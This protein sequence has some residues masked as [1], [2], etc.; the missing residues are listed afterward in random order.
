MIVKKAE[1]NGILELVDK[2]NFR[3][4]HSN[5]VTLSAVEVFC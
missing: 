4:S 3:N 5:N 2:I 1:E